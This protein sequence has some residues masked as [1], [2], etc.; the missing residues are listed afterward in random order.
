MRGVSKVVDKS[1]FKRKKKD[2]AT[3]V[4]KILGNQPSF[5]PK[6]NFS[7]VS[8]QRGKIMNIK[9]GRL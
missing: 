3:G 8:G 9:Q 1:L 2:N 6:K 5:W 7:L 4:S